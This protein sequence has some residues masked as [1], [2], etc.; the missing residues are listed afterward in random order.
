MKHEKIATIQVGKRLYKIIASNHSQKRMRQRKIDSYT[1]VG[2]I[3]LLG[4]IELKTPKSHDEFIIIDKDT[5]H[6]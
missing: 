6:L 5:I 4:K 1:I 2:N 3:L